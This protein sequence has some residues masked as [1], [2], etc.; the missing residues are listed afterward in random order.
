ML[1]AIPPNTDP[2]F[3]QGRPAECCF[4]A[5]SVQSPFKRTVVLMN[6]GNYRAVLLSNTTPNCNFGWQDILPPG[7][8]TL[9]PATTMSSMFLNGTAVI[10]DFRTIYLD[11]LTHDL[12]MHLDSEGDGTTLNGFGMNPTV[13]GER[14][15]IMDNVYDFQVSF[16]YD[17]DYS[18]D[19]LE[20]AAA[21]G[22]EWLYNFPGEGSNDFSDPFDI[23]RLRLIRVEAVVGLPT[24]GAAAGAAVMSPARTPLGITV[25]HVALRAVGTRLAPRN[26]DLPTFN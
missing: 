25:P 22:D 14:M 23:T 16:G 7:M 21:R 26:V 13:T 12:V 5:G 17:L 3:P 8:R 10:V 2:S 15:R 1:P 20:T 19:V 4:T 11:T 24:E 9:T 6:N 18:G